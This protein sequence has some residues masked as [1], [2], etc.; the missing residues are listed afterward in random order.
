MKTTNALK[1]RQS[2]G[3]ILAELARDGEPIIVE[4]DRKP[5]AVLIAIDDFKRRYADRE[6]DA[7]R[8]ELVARLGSYKLKLPKGKSSLRLIQEARK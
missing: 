2:L 5:A 4:K 8:Q 1:L 7:M 6:A 3:K